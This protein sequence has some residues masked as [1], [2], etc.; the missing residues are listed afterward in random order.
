MF[1]QFIL[2][3]REGLEAALI[4]AIIDAYLR[5]IGRNDLNKYLYLGSCLAVLASAVLSVIFW[6]LY[7]FAEGL[8]GLWFEALAMFTATAVLTYMIL[9]MAKNAR[10]I[11]G[12]LQEKVDVAISS[13]QL[14]GISA[15]AFTSVLREGVETILF[16][17]AA[18]AISF[19][20]TAIGAIL[21]LLSATVVAV[22]LMR[23]TVKLDWRRFFLYT[24]VLLLLFASGITMHGAQALEELGVL[25]PIIE[26]VYDVNAV[27]PE[28]GPLG[29]VLH[30]F[31]GYHDAPPLLILIVQFSYL[32][33]FGIYV[34]KV[35]KPTPEAQSQEHMPRT[36]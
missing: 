24:S 6:T 5:K 31:I 19:A 20:E 35:Y 11:R 1:V 26:K 25:P 2:T 22:F 9:W 15:V 32:A 12:E 33:I 13:G 16:L 28:E 14:L 10:K 34:Y 3:L 23:G 36:A 30:V 27:L 7:G 4:I 18:A 29:S 8:A 21:G 17:S